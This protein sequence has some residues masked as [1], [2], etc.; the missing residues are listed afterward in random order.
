MPDENQDPIIE[1][2]QPTGETSEPVPEP[3]RVPPTGD[4]GDMPENLRSE[5]DRVMSGEPPPEQHQIEDFP[6]PKPEE[7]SG[8]EAAAVE[9]PRPGELPGEEPSEGE[10]PYE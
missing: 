2:H 3:A 8:G 10:D 9:G 6:T 1:G 4:V 5:M 7:Y